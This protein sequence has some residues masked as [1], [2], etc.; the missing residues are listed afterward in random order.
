MRDGNTPGP[1]AR[2]LTQ[3]G[4]IRRER[5]DVAGTAAAYR[6]A[7]TLA[8]VAGEEL[9]GAQAT[10]F[11]GRCL[12]GGSEPATGLALLS[13]AVAR[14]RRLGGGGSVSPCRCARWVICSPATSPPPAPMPR[15]A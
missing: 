2:V 15:S 13:D 8:A 3:L 10:A 7:M 5:S 11:L 1:L 9:I 6:E 4:H 14:L 12:L